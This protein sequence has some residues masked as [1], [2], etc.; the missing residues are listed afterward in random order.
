MTSEANILTDTA[1][2]V[3]AAAGVGALA[4][5]LRVPLVLAYL[6]AG[7][8]LGPNL[9]FGIISNS[10]SID[11][12]T[13]LGL[14]LLMFILGVE[15]DLRK[16]AQA[17]R[18]V[19]LNGF[20]Q[21]L[22]CA[23]MGAGLFYALGF[24]NESGHHELTYLAVIGALSSTV[25]V[26]KVLLDRREADSFTS[27]ITIG[28]LVIQDLWAITFLALQPSLAPLRPFEAFLSFGRALMLVGFSLG[29]ARHILP[30]VFHR[31]AKNPE[32]M[33]L[34]TLSWCL[35]IAELA[36]A[37]HLSVEMGALIAGVTVASFPYHS[38]MAAKVG[39]LRDFFV[40]LFF[41][42]LGMRIPVPTL[43]VIEFA[44]VLVVFAIIS[45]I[46]TV[47][48]VLYAMGYG[49]RA[50]LIPA[51]NL[52]QLS[53][54]SLIA[55]TLGVGYGH[56]SPEFLS[57]VTI[58]VV[59]SFVISSGTLAHSYPLAKIIGRWGSMLGFHDRGINENAAQE[60][61]SCDTS[62]RFVI[63]GFF[64]DASSLLEELR[65]RHGDQIKERILMVD[66]NPESFKA[67]K[68]RG[69]NCRYADISHLDTLTQLRLNDDQTIICTVPDVRLKG[70]TNLRLL[71]NLRGLVPNARVVVTAETRAEGA[72]LYNNGASYVY[73][74]RVISS[75]HLADLLERLDTPEEDRIRAGGLRFFEERDEVLP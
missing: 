56:V 54:F 10:A 33:L 68:S 75:Y 12:I 3:M 18:A 13:E 11:G 22:L 49:T 57:T 15:I 32:L 48:P 34:A 19:L 36:Q 26:V 67:L 9:G 37:L 41:V 60:G 66:Y 6:L 28:I 27:R 50:S 30:W 31:I 23:G 4:T 52:G 71:R 7:V 2:A 53:E 25:L 45:R 70:T 73:F 63:L 58:A 59:G 43:S 46:L 64:R 61:L 74:P 14:V 42:S 62:P 65:Q 47:T 69:Y 39:S 44:G 16:L 17:G 5:A 40:T 29:M 20:S 35:G 51:I 24:R 38:D 8:A 55:T 1:T 21:F 72:A